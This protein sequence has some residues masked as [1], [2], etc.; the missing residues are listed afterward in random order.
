MTIYGGSLSSHKF[1]NR[2]VSVVVDRHEL[3]KAR[4]TYPY[5]T[6]LALFNL[7]PDGGAGVLTSVAVQ[8][9]GRALL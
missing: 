2:K 1:L 6:A 4:G 3:V 7:S 9:R 5:R 8:T